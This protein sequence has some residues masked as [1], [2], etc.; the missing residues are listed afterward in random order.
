MTITWVGTKTID[1]W[2]VPLNPTQ[3]TGWVLSVEGKLALSATRT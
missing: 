3:Q 1:E 2:D